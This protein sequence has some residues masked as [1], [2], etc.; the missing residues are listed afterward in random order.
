MAEPMSAARL[1][2]IRE[3]AE[4][5]A[6]GS[7]ALSGWDGGYAT[8]TFRPRI[9]SEH[10]MSTVAELAE[11][12][13]ETLIALL[14]ELDRVTEEQERTLALADLWRAERDMEEDRA[15]R[16]EAAL[17]RVTD[18]SMAETIERAMYASWTAEEEHMQ[19]PRAILAAIRGVA[20]EE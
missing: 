8:I 18:D 6:T 12:V 5:L 1:A 7:L 2:K 11:D 10:E 3:G 16:A 9:A 19:S 20:A 13:P 15:D 17:A 14:A 4:V